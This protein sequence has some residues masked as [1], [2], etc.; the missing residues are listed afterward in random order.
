MVTHMLALT[1]WKPSVSI[2]FGRL[3]FRHFFNFCHE[4]QPGFVL[5]GQRV[6][7]RRPAGQQAWLDLSA[8]SLW[9]QLSLKSTSST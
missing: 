1:L 5:L 2:R 9:G 6:S 8:L 7:L 4:R 3:L